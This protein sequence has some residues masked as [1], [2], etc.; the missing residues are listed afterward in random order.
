MTERHE[1]VLIPCS[2]GIMLLMSALARAIVIGTGLLIPSEP[3]VDKSGQLFGAGILLILLSLFGGGLLSYG[4]QS[5]MQ[6]A[7]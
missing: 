7:K 1:N 2:L 4:F 5:I 3:Y 6:G